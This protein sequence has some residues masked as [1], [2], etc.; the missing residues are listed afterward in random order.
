MSISRGLRNN[1]PLIINQ[2]SPD[3][4]E[5]LEGN[6]PDGLLIFNT[7]IDG[8]RAGMI[9]LYKGY[10]WRGPTIRQ[11]SERYLPDD[12]VYNQVMSAE[13]SRHLEL[14]EDVSIPDEKWKDVPC[15]VAY[16]ASGW[17]CDLDKI[18]QAVE[19]LPSDNM[20]DLF[21]NAKEYKPFAPAVKA[22]NDKKSF[23]EKYKTFLIYGGIGLLLLLLLVALRKKKK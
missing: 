9:N 16:F 13:L 15:V 4:W 3:P 21:R 1:N 7:D 19:R 2:S 14:D 6:D 17:E 10:Y 23:F 18:N 22:V 5:G 11:L 12:P 8:L 20:K